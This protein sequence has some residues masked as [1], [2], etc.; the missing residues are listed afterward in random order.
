MAKSLQTR[1]KTIRKAI[2]NYNTAARL[3]TPPRPELHWTDVSHYGLIEQYAL[4]KANNTDISNKEWSQP[5]FREV[6]K[7]RRRIAR[8]KEEITRCNVEVRRLH[9][10]IYDDA[11][12]FKSVVKQLRENEDSMYS[13]VRDFARRRNAI[14]KGLLKRVR[15]IYSLVG[16]T[17]D[18]SPGIRVGRSEG[19][20]IPVTPD[21]EDETGGNSLLVHEEEEWEQEEEEGVE[22]DDELHREVDG[23]ENFLCTT[24]D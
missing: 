1:S 20:T 3:L 6:L 5:V 11:V 19:T 18:P 22:S 7:C 24:R 17:G 16:F 10:G 21:D 12:H 14:H 23:V 4:L 9:T 13:A 2:T 15:Q 8:A